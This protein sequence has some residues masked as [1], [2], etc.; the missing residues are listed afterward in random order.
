MIVGRSFEANGLF[1]LIYICASIIFWIIAGVLIRFLAKPGRWVFAGIAIGPMLIM[2]IVLF[3]LNHR[4]MP[5]M[6]AVGS[7]NLPL[8][9]MHLIDS[10]RSLDS[11][12]FVFFQNRDGTSNKLVYVNN[13]A[14]LTSADFKRASLWVRGDIIGIEIELTDSGGRKLTE[15]TSH[16]VG[17]DVAVVMDGQLCCVEPISGVV[18]LGRF[19]VTGNWTVPEAKALIEKLNLF[20]RTGKAVSP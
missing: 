8:F 2:L 13:K 1:L 11:K 5:E 18:T 3:G 17:R 15:I 20:S 12:E 16:N 19:D 4:N 14:L 10:A 6:K 7:V 9:E